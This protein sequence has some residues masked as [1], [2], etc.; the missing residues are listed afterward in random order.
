MEYREY[1]VVYRR[2]ASLFFIVGTD[3]E[4][5]VRT[6][7]MTSQERGLREPPLLGARGGAYVCVC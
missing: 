5:E 3:Q 2:Y 4:G 1:K 7:T 6:D